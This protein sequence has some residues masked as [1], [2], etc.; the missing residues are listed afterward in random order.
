MGMP[1][2]IQPK[3][4]ILCVIFFSLKTETV[5]VGKL[6]E[7]YFRYKSIL[8]YNLLSRTFANIVFMLLSLYI[9]C[10]YILITSFIL[11][12]FIQNVMKKFYENSRIF[13]TIF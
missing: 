12:Y 7:K 4:V 1:G 8:A 6:I 9:L 11:G 2:H 5:C 3:V 10:L 13:K